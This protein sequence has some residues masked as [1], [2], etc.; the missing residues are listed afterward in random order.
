MPSRESHKGAQEK[1]ILL[2]EPEMLVISKKGDLQDDRAEEPLAESF[3]R[4]VDAYGVRQPIS[5]RKNTETGLT[6]VVDGRQRWLR[7]GLGRTVGRF[8]RLG[9]PDPACER[10]DRSG[11]GLITPGSFAAD[12]L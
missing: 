1:K 4:N 12:P 2:F 5:V 9:A 10:G 8:H 11:A 3:V 6:E 7:T